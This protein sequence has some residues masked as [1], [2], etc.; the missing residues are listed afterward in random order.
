MTR[1]SAVE[2]SPRTA[3]E[4]FAF[5]RDEFLGGAF[6]AWW[7]SACAVGVII[8][9]AMP[10]RGGFAG[11]FAAL[12]MTLC[13]A[14]LGFPAMMLLAPVVWIIGR[15]MRTVPRVW[16]HLGVQAAVGLVLGMLTTIAVLSLFG[17]FPFFLGWV[18]LLAAGPAIG[19]PVAWYRAYRRALRSDA[20]LLTRRADPDA[21]AEDAIA[22]RSRS[23]D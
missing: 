20:G 9:A 21:V 3:S 18:P 17:A 14:L 23:A 16:V 4:P 6:A 11:V 22:E 8:L 1:T 19:L 10:M 7:L 13:A 2:P 15:S 12:V 5:T